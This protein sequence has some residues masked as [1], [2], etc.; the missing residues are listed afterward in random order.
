MSE[1]NCEARLSDAQIRIEK[2]EGSLGLAEDENKSLSATLRWVVENNVCFAENNGKI[3]AWCDYGDC[4]YDE[5]VPDEH[6]ENIENL[7]VNAKLDET[8]RVK[9]DK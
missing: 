9:E 6:W 4:C 3:N 7:F 2:L 5:P 8:H 1:H